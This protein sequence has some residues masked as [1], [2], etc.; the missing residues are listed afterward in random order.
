[1]G[2]DIHCS[3]FAGIQSAEELNFY[4]HTKILTIVIAFPRLVMQHDSAIASVP[5]FPAFDLLSYKSVVEPQLAIRKRVFLI[6]MGIGFIKGIIVVI[7]N[8]AHTVFYSKIVT[9]VYI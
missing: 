2:T 4:W 5:V 1:M 7:Y 3:A 9:V 8:P 6:H